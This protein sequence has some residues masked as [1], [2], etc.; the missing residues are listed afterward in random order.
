VS[1]PVPFMRRPETEIGAPPVDRDDPRVYHVIRVDDVGPADAALLGAPF[2]GGVT[3]GGGRA[4]AAEGPAAVRRALRRAGTTYHLDHD[5]SLDDLSVVDAGDLIATPDTAETHARLEAAVGAL[6]ARGAVPIVIG[7]GH[8]LTYATV[9][10]L[11]RHAGGP[12]GGVSIDAHLDVRPVRDGRITSGTPFRRLLEELPGFTGE[13]F[14]VLGPHGNRNA[15]A[16][17]EWLRGRGGQIVTLAEARRLGAAAAMD[18]ALV[19]AAGAA[20]GAAA[21]SGSFHHGGTEDSEEYTEERQRKASSPCTS[22]CP[23]CLRGEK[24]AGTRIFVSLDIDAA[25]QAF[26]PGSSAPSADGFQPDEL[27][28]LAFLAGRHPQVACFDVMEVNPRF[29]HDDRTAALAA[30]AIVQFLFGLAQRGKAQGATHKAQ[31]PDPGQ[32]S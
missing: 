18:A 4:G 7:G 27:L 32:S 8:D 26:A 17:V 31:R 12:V 21:A 28:S 3:A 24:P 25:A 2:D 13:R 1:S 9:A 20:S 6:L 15:R 14:V 11:A 5:L 22:P 30:A 19:R 16:H 29:D 10:A 23:P